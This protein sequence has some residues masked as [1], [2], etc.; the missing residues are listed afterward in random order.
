LFLE[1][2]LKQYFQQ[3]GKNKKHKAWKTELGLNGKQVKIL[4]QMQ[5]GQETI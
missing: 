2:I 3:I 1:N 5:F 4:V